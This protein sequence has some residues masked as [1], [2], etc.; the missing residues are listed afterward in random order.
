M[1]LSSRRTPGVRPQR[2]DFVQQVEYEGDA[3]RVDLEVVRQPL[4]GPDTAQRRATE[5]PVLR[6][7][8]SGSNTP[9][10]THSV[11]SSSDAPVTRHSSTSVN[12]TSSSTSWP[13]R[14]V[15][16]DSF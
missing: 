10:D 8:P 5:A 9:S 13:S 3:R 14:W 6:S 15:V 4:R 16:S 12:S 1:D 11:N 2:V 7:V